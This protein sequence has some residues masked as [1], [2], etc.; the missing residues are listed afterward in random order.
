MTK[1]TAV[2]QF[3]L[4]DFQTVSKWFFTLSRNLQKRAKARGVER[5]GLRLDST[6]NAGYADIASAPI[7]VTGELQ[8]RK[9]GVAR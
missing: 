1:Q 3:E 7:L 8:K 9:R 2:T 4:H 5:G 6:R